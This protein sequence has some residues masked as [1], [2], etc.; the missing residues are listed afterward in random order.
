[1]LLQSPLT[2]HSNERTKSRGTFDID[3]PVIA[4]TAGARFPITILSFFLLLS[5]Q[6]FTHISFM[7][8][9]EEP[10]ICSCKS[11]LQKLDP[12][13]LIFAQFLLS[14]NKEQPNFIATV[15]YDEQR[16]QPRITLFRCRINEY[17]TSSFSFPF[18]AMPRTCLSTSPVFKPKESCSLS[19]RHR[20][21]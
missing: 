21:I 6:S 17:K 16:A 12:R 19:P 18:V 15:R 1:M 7:S 2:K 3:A 9:S 11:D 5:F 10:S 4:T 14:A 20:N 8:V 13:H